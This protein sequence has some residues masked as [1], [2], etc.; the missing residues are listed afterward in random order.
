MGNIRS[1]LFM[2]LATVMYN[3]LQSKGKID[4]QMTFIIPKSINQPYADVH[5]DHKEREREMGIHIVVMVNNLPAQPCSLRRSL[6]PKEA[7]Q[8]TSN[9]FL[10]C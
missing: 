3:P 9:N 5:L 10:H 1:Y 2:E 6:Q 7:V 4:N 8:A